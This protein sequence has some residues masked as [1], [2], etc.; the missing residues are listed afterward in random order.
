MPEETPRQ[1]AEQK[2]QWKSEF[3]AELLLALTQPEH[4]PIT[5]YVRLKEALGSCE[6]W[7][8]EEEVA[9]ARQ[10]LCIRRQA[11]DQDIDRQNKEFDED[12]ARRLAARQAEDERYEVQRKEE[13]RAATVLSRWW[14][15]QTQDPELAEMNGLIARADEVE[16]KEWLD[17]QRKKW[18]KAAEEVKAASKGRGDGAAPKGS[19][20]LG[21]FREIRPEPNAGVAGSEIIA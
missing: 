1:T 21:G 17:Q 5:A 20:R 9:E 6:A 7:L 3:R 19:A 14:R 8:P 4:C 12:I 11:Y 2:E 16:Q 13:C 15:R 10:E 18:A